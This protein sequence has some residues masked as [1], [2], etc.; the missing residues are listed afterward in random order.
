MPIV[1]RK[2]KQL[3]LPINQLSAE[4]Y[5]NWMYEHPDEAKK[6]D[7]PTAAPV[8]PTVVWRNGVAVQ[9]VNNSQTVQNGVIQG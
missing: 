1:T 6:L 2:G 5:K 7:T 9:I 3:D 8:V 4:E